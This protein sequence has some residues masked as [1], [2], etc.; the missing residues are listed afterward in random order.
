MESTGASVTPRCHT[1]TRP[2]SQEVS[3]CVPEVLKPT[4]LTGPS[5]PLYKRLPAVL[6]TGR[7]SRPPLIGVAASPPLTQYFEKGSLVIAAVP[8]S[9]AVARQE[10]S[11]EKQAWEIG[12]PC[13]GCGRS[14]SC[15]C[16]T[17]IPDKVL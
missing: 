12:L 4:L 11:G 17:G 3:K 8:S 10:A 6:I 7:A 13:N 9:D 5:W 16:R 15:W 2:S 1:R 14:C